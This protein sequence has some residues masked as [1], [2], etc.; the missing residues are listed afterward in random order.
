MAIR[1]LLDSNTASYIVKGKPLR[2]RERLI[3]VPIRQVGLSVVTEAEL[4]FGV[5]RLPQASKLEI[6]IEEFLRRIEVV[7]WD[8][9]SARRYAT[10][11]AELERTGEPVGNLDLMIAAQ[12][13]VIGA[14]L[15]SSDR[16]FRKIRELTVEDWAR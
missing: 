13:L 8:S 2:V 16:T 10:L 6:V 14:I 4:R 7:V 12:A 1:Y 5:A 15:V 9:N 3:E 11:R